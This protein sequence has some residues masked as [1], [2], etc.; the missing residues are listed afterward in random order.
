VATLVAAV[1]TLSGRVGPAVSGV[2]ALF[3]V[4]FSSMMLI[5]HPRIGGPAAAA[6]IANSA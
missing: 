1:V 4:V 5:L 2:I 6:V 3:P